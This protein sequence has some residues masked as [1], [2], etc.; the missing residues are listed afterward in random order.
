[1]DMDQDLGDSESTDGTRD[2]S[3][4]TMTD[5]N[6]INPNQHRPGAYPSGRKVPDNSGEMKS[7]STRMFTEDRMMESTITGIQQFGML[8]GVALMVIFLFLLNV[9]LEMTF[10]KIVDSFSERYKPTKKAD[11]EIANDPA[12]LVGTF[13]RYK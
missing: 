12:S 10:D 4:V 9:C 8:V 11:E 6:T 2:E 13:K 1:M 5:I 7:T 3:I